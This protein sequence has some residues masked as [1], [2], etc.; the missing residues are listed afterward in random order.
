MQRILIIGGSGSGKSTFARKIAER[1]GLPVIHLDQRYFGPGWKEP[2]QED[3]RETT[4]ALAAGDRWVMDGNYSGTFAQ[5]M[6]R[7]DTVI[8]LDQPSWRCLWRV[9]LRTLRYYGKPRPS[10]APDC[11]ERFDAHFLHYVMAYNR[12]RRPGILRRLAEEAEK[13]KMIHHLQ[14]NRAAKAFLKSLPPYPA[15]RE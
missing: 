4:A 10:S 9:V 1:T 13:G 11:P 14:G 7:A 12:S 3:W 6:P 2:R 15:G 8:Y 5:R